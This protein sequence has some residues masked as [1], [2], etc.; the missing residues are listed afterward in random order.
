MRQYSQASDLSAAATREPTNAATQRQRNLRQRQDHEPRNA[1]GSR[2]LR[3]LRDSFG[4]ELFPYGR[5]PER[6]TPSRD[7]QENR[8]GARNFARAQRSEMKSIRRRGLPA[9]F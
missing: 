4:Q 9:G 8:K 5:R 3:A 6:S 2:W 1:A 7:P